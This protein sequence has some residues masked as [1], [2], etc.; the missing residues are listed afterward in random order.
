MCF[1]NFHCLHSSN[2]DNSGYIPIQSVSLDTYINNEENKKEE[3]I[4]HRYFDPNFDT[5]NFSELQE[6]EKN[7]EP[8]KIIETKTT[9]KDGLFATIGNKAITKSDIINEIKM[10]LILNNKSYSQEESQQLQNMAVK[11]LIKRNVKK[12]EVE[13]Y[14]FNEYSQN[15]FNKELIR[16]SKNLNMNLERLKEICKANDLDFAIVEDQIKTDL[17]W[18]SLIFQTYKDRLSINLEEIDDQIKTIQNKKDNEEYLI[19]E[20]VIEKVEKDKIKSTIENL[21]NRIESEGFENVAINSSISDSSSRGG[22]LGWINENLI[23]EKL[24][25]V[26]L[27]LNCVQLDSQSQQID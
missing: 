11:A 9:I 18:N 8:K 23:V 7:I 19:S 3:S 6:E 17:R 1:T 12:I 21:K 26:K 15:D 13:K 16:L 5:L 22:N 20:I 4:I 14:N 24:H 25:Y 10:I 27:D 2:N